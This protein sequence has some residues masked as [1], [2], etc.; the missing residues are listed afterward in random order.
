[1]AASK[2]E[3]FLDYLTAPFTADSLKVIDKFDPNN[4]KTYGREWY[5]IELRDESIAPKPAETHKTGIYDG[6]CPFSIGVGFNNSDTADREEA[7]AKAETILRTLG[8]D[9][10]T[11]NGERVTISHVID[12]RTFRAYSDKDPFGM[13]EIQGAIKYRLLTA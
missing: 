9:V 1:M 11:I 8:R 7:I 4:A 13:A 2:G 5:V 12:I 3:Y 6:E 10:E